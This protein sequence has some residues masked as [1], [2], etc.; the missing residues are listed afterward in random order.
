MTLSNRHRGCHQR[1]AVSIVLVAVL[2]VCCVVPDGYQVSRWRAYRVLKLQYS[3]LKR[4][5][6]GELSVFI[7][8]SKCDTFLALLGGGNESIM[9][10]YAM[11][12]PIIYAPGALPMIM[13][14]AGN[15]KSAFKKRFARPPPPPSGLVW[16]DR[17]NEGQVLQQLVPLRGHDRGVVTH[18]SVQPVLNH[19]RLGITVTV[20]QHWLRS[21]RGTN[22]A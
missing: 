4:S 19:Y 16:R 17:V 3:L 1:N 10:W 11:A 5:S 12:F 15:R 18:L 20:Q 21:D 7:N 14:M 22:L 13:N 8:S 2:F 9:Y 6:S